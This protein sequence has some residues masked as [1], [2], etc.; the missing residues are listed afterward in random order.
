MELPP[1]SDDYEY[2]YSALQHGGFAILFIFPALALIVVLLRVYTR[3]SMKQFGL[4]TCD[5]HITRVSL[6]LLRRS[7]ADHLHHANR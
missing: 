7:F 4:G 1:F 5:D 6:F 3:L 2:P